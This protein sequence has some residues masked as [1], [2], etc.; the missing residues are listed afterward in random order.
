MGAE[1]RLKTGRCCQLYGNPRGRG[2]KIGR[3]GGGFTA[4][5]S[6][7][8]K[9][10]FSVRLS[11]KKTWWRTSPARYLCAV[12]ADSPEV[13]PNGSNA[14]DFPNWQGAV[15]RRGLDAT[16]RALPW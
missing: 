15:Q 5:V 1:V 7:F 14:V 4:G 9:D 3:V 2:G 8:G 16:D 12:A 6:T 11:R 10:Q 13:L